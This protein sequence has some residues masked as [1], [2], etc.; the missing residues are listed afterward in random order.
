LTKSEN[1]SVPFF[2]KQI[3]PLFPFFPHH[4]PI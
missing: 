4:Q 2:R 1:K 3:R